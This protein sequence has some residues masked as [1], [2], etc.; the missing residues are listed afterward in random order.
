[1][2]KINF[3]KFIWVY[4]RMGKNVFFFGCFSNS[5]IEEKKMNER[6]KKKNEAEPEMCYCPT[7]DT[8]EIVS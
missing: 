4:L 2:D 8:M 7:V 6:K 3:Y 5:R 1:M